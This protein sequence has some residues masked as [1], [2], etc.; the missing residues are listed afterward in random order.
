MQAL[1]RVLYPYADQSHGDNK[2]LK[3]LEE[4]LKRGARAGF[5]L[6]SQPSVWKFDW[7]R[8]GDIKAGTM[9]IFPALVKVGDE[10]GNIISPPRVLVEG[11]AASGFIRAM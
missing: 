9:T 8:H 2:R 7:D 5:L 10:N 11:E 1:N 3:N 4:I 6:F